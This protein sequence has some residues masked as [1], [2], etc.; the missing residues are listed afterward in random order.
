M[1]CCLILGSMMMTTACQKDLQSDNSDTAAAVLADSST[2]ADNAYSDGFTNAFYGYSEDVAAAVGEKHSGV[3]ATNGTASGQTV[4]HFSC[5]TAS[6]YTTGGGYPVTLSL[7]FGNGCTSNDSIT[8]RGKISYTYSGP[9]YSSGSSITVLF[10]NYYVNGYG[11][12]GLYSITNS[13]SDSTPQ[14]AEHVTNG[15]FSYPDGSNYHYTSNKVITM[16]AGAST[17]LYFQDDVYSISGNSNFSSSSGNSVVLTVTTPLVK[18]LI[19]PSVSSGIIS[20]VYNTRIKGTIDFGNGDC[21]NIATLT[22]GGT[23]KTIALR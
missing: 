13:S 22:A 7:D 3:V 10:D 14:F 21:D 1:S 23:V 6:V 5:A 9:I 15:I 8:R 4:V 18:N 19:C 17:P 12:Q 2:T 20:F 16:T 11:L